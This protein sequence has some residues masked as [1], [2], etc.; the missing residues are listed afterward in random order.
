[1]IFKVNQSRNAGKAC[2]LKLPKEKKIK[3]KKLPK[4]QNTQIV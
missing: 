2:N 1:M 4:E 3:K